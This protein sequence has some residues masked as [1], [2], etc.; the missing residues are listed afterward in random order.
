MVTMIESNRF[1]TVS[2][3]ITNT[4]DV[5]NLPKRGLTTGS[6]AI[7]YATDGNIRVW[8]FI[9]NENKELDGTWAEMV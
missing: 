9:A 6:T 2:Y 1:G 4:S 7:L 3:S 5:N 8:N